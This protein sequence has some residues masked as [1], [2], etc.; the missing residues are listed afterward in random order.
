MDASDAGKLPNLILAMQTRA[1][2]MMDSFPEYTKYPILYGMLVKDI[3]DNPASAPADIEIFGHDIVDPSVGKAPIVKIMTNPKVDGGAIEVPASLT[4]VSGDDI[5]ADLPD[6]AKDAIQFAP[7]SCQARNTFLVRA[8]AYYG[9]PHGIWP[10]RFITTVESNS[11]FHALPS[12]RAFDFSVEYEFDHSENLVATEKFS[13]RSDYVV[14]ECGQTATTSFSYSP[15]SGGHDPTCSVSWSEESGS[16]ASTKSCEVAGN[17]VSAKGSLTGADR[18]CSMDKVCGC[19]ENA[20]GWLQ[21]DG[22]YK[23]DTVV[24]E[25]KRVSMPNKFLAIANEPTTIP[26]ALQQDA[27]LKH[28]GIVIN[29]RSCPVIYDR[30]DVQFNSDGQ[31]ILSGD[32]KGGRFRAEFANGQLKIMNS[33]I[34]GG[35]DEGSN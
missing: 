9:E 5:L 12:P 35:E 25:M 20:R 24:V 16:K 23:R 13:D 28:V 8:T 31:R 34:E 10:V 21:V 11:D 29:R 17:V 2:A 4:K 26:I 27:R 33:S 6:G 32:S 15:P 18:V 3:A 14:A 22:V 7:T 19:L 1:N 30:L